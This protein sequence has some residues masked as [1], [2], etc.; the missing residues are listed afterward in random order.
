MRVASYH[1]F[2]LIAFLLFA[3]T[4]HAFVM[5]KN[6]GALPVYGGWMPGTSAQYSAAASTAGTQAAIK[7][8]LAFDVTTAQGKSTVNATAEYVAGSGNGSVV[9]NAAKAALGVGTAVAAYSG[10]REQ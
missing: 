10:E 3:T 7:E 4:S 2:S 1:H 9:S 8:S 5:P 6:T